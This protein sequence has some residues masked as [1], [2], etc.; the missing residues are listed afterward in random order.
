MFLLF[1]GRHRLRPGVRGMSQSDHYLNRGRARNT[2]FETEICNATTCTS[3]DSHS[4]EL[5]LRSGVS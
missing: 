3:V 2:P 1:F 5:V 4:D